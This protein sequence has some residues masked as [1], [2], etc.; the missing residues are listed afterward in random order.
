MQTA[1]LSPM[2]REQHAAIQECWL[3]PGAPCWAAL[4]WVRARWMLLCRVEWLL[5]GWVWVS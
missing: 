3:R 5:L 4:C 1:M 2:G